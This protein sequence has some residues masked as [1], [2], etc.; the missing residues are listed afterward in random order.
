MHASNVLWE[1]LWSEVFYIVYNMPG[2]SFN[3]AWSLTP[4]ERRWWIRKFVQ[5]KEKEIEAQNKHG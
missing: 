3:D 4:Y 1:V 5:Q 2:M